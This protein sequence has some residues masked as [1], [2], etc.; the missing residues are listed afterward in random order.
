[1]AEL[2]L[3]LTLTSTA[4]K[5]WP[6]PFGGVWLSGDVMFAFT[7]H[8]SELVAVLPLPFVYHALPL[9]AL[10]DLKALFMRN[11]M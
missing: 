9:I 2:N 6:K 11:T 5:N 3:T 4:G 8:E 7:M 1:M 10:K